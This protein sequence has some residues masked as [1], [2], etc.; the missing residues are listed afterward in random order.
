MTLYA[1]WEAISACDATCQALRVGLSAYYPLDTD[2]NDYSGN[3]VNLSV[4]GAIPATGRVGQSYNLNG[5]TDYL[6]SADNSYLDL[7]GPG[8]TLSEWF[9]IDSFTTQYSPII[10]KGVYMTV[11]SS[12][13][14]VGYWGVISQDGGIH[15]EVSGTDQYPDSYCGTSGGL[16]STGGWNHVTFIWDDAGYLK[17]YLNGVLR[18][19]SATMQGAWYTGD[20]STNFDFLVGSLPS[21]G[22]WTDGKVDEIGIWNRAL[23]QTEISNLYNGGS[24]RSLK[25]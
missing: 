3:D 11:Y 21:L 18:N 16:V 9:Y 20:A 12:P 10:T 15:F 7:S 19:C 8:R 6:S 23:S 22:W 4:N 24:G 5:S 17:I 25:L 2:A 14:A 13:Q 1:Q